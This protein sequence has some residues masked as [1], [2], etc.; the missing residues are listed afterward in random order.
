MNFVD[1]YIT[2]LTN[3]QKKLHDIINHVKKYD[4]VNVNDVLLIFNEVKKLIIEINATVHSFRGEKGFSQTAFPSDKWNE[5]IVTMHTINEV[6]LTESN[7]VEKRTASFVIEILDVMDR[8]HEN[9]RD[10][11]LQLA[12]SRWMLTLTCVLQ[13]LYARCSICL[14]TATSHYTYLTK[15]THNASHQRRHTENSLFN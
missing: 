6:L 1:L 8:C 5:S 11:L 2:N 4:I 14:D 9:T 3:A 13:A 7:D 12:T 15:F 10:V